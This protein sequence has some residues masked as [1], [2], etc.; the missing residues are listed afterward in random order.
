MKLRIH[1]QNSRVQTVQVEQWISNF[2]KHIMMDVITYSIAIEVFYVSVKETT[3]IFGK[4][5]NFR[6]ESTFNGMCYYFL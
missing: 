3:G 5:V 1:Y 2:I 6:H 4:A